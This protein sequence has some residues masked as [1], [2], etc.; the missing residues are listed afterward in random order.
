MGLVAG[1]A[2]ASASGLYASFYYAGGAAGA[3]IPGLFWK[4]G[5]WPATVG[6]IVVVLTAT[7]VIAA[8]AWNRMPVVA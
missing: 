6:F 2:R 7:A 5:G 3:F 1:K 8:R 4:L